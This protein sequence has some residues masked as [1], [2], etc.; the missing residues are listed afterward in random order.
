MWGLVSKLFTKAFSLKA[1]IKVA[2]FAFLWNNGKSASLRE[3]KSSPTFG[4]VFLRDKKHLTRLETKNT[5]AATGE[6]C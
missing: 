4:M 6:F 5:K 1:Q 2:F 3:K